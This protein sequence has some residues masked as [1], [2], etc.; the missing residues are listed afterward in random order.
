MGG[1]RRGSGE[2]EADIAGR[3]FGEHSSR[4]PR[5]INVGYTGELLPGKST[6]DH[7]T[8]HDGPGTINVA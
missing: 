4:V 6:S 7:G 3:T 5:V 2:A 1:I 8:R